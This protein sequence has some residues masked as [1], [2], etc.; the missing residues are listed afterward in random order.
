ML[1]FLFP[2]AVGIL[3]P[4]GDGCACGFGRLPGGAGRSDGVGI[5]AIEHHDQAVV[6]VEAVRRGTVDEEA[7]FGAVGIFGIGGEVD[8]LLGREAVSLGAVRQKAFWFVGPEPLIEAVEALG[9]AGLDHGTPAA[10]KR[11]LKQRRQDVFERLALEM[12][13]QDFRRHEARCAISWRWRLCGFVGA[14]SCGV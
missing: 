6:G 14:V 13:E 7:D 8:R 12:I 1:R 5:A 10:L 11:A 3:L 4:V 2:A 9:R